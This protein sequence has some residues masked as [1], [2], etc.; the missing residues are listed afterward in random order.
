MWIAVS[1]VSIASQKPWF[2]L[3]PWKGAKTALFMTEFVAEAI[4]KCTIHKRPL[5][6]RGGKERPVLQA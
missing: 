1:M 3:H 6:Y 2:S 4:S 5:F